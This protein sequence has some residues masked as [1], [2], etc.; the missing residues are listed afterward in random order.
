MTSHPLSLF[1]LRSRHRRAPTS[2]KKAPRRLRAPGLSQHSP[3]SSSSQL[4]LATEQQAHQSLRPLHA[5]GVEDLADFPGHRLAR[6]IEEHRETFA[7][8]HE[9]LPRLGERLRP[10][11]LLLRRIDVQ[12]D[13]VHQLQ[14]V[15]EAFGARFRI[16]IEVQV[17][18]GLERPLPIIGQLQGVHPVARRQRRLRPTGSE[19]DHRP[20]F[21]GR[22]LD[23]PVGFLIAEQ[24]HDVHGRGPLRDHDRA[25][26]D[27]QLGFA[28]GPVD[29]LGA[30]LAF[31]IDRVT[32][33][34]RQTQ[35]SL[36][37][38]QGRTGD[39]LQLTGGR[40]REQ[41]QVG[42][43]ELF[44]RQRA[45]QDHPADGVEPFE[46]LFGEEGTDGGGD[47]VFRH[48]TNREKSCA[49]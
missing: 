26:P 44:D 40:V 25:E 33:P 36:R 27:E 16:G 4:E 2:N 48:W 9:H 38:D 19:R 41:V 24:H 35:Q 49:A 11:Q 45:F 30:D 34:R 1:P 32:M 31:A 12:L 23:Q 7:D 21:D 28:D 14:V 13:R 18:V 3:L 5:F 15:L 10:A 22:L 46:G 43:R 17:A 20:E 37:V 8:R 39:P 29:Q 6:L 42:E 47:F